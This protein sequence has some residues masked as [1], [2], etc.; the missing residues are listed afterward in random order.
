MVYFYMQIQLGKNKKNMTYAPCYHCGEPCQASIFEQAGCR[1]DEKIFCCQGCLAVYEL[2]KD[3]ELCQYYDLNDKAGISQKI[4]ARKEKFIY[5]DLPEVQAKL[6]DFTD[7]KTANLTL[8]IPAIHCS[9]CIW[10]LEHL[11]KLNENIHFSQINFLKKQLAIRFDVQKIKLSEVAALLASIGYEPLITLNDVQEEN[12]LQ[13]DRKTQQENRRLIAQIAVAGFVFGNV[14]MLSFPEY[15]GFD[16]LSEQNL[17]YVFNALNLVFSLPVLFFSGQDYITTA[18][19]NLRKGILHVDFPL[20]LGMLVLW[21]RSIFEIITETGAGYIDSMSGLIFFL[22]IGK[23]FQQRTYQ[24]M[25]YDR[26]FKSYFPIAVLVKDENGN[27]KPMQ[28]NDLASGNKIVI[29]NEEIIPADTQLLRGN[30]QIDYSFVTGEASPIQKEI[31]ETIYAGG[32]QKGE[33]IELLVLKK[34]SQSYLTQL[35]NNENFDKNKDENS[36][37]QAILNRYFTVVLILIACLSASYWLVFEKNIAVAINVFTAVLVIACPCALSLGSQFA[38]GTAM[39]ILG[40]H[41]FYLKNVHTVEQIAENDTIVFDKTGT[42]TENKES[43]IIFEPHN[44]L[45]SLQGL[46]E[47]EIS[48]ILA[49][50]RNSTHPLSVK[51]TNFLKENGYLI[52]PNQA[53]EIVSFKEQMGKGLEGIVGGSSVMIGSKKWLLEK[54]V[55]GFSETQANDNELDTKVFIALNGM[56]K[57]CF[58]FKNTYR[59]GIEQTIKSLVRADLD[60]YLLSGDNEGEKKNL[61]RLFPKENNL[62]FQQNPH[63][64][65]AFIKGLQAKN[66]HVMM[67]GDGLN[68][69]GALLQSDTGI[70]VTENTAYF[71]PAS[72]AIL[73]ASVLSKLPKFIKF[74]RFAV[75][76]IRQSFGI[77]LLYNLIGLFFAVQ[78]LLSPLVAAILMPVSSLTVILFTTWGVKRFK[79]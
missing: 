40:Q 66:R 24:T 60:L 53:A 67:V 62:Y 58:V 21:G 71:T 19:K 12:D 7:G 78:G 36:L 23:W 52:F 48:A 74:C 27:E 31:G 44:H 79:L 3:N 41:K 65:L 20:A 29:R 2:L 8:F 5:L 51:I 9:S 77:A 17:R 22:L 30:A 10:L 14:M 13:K 33:Q 38:L 69:A 18:Y 75:N 55:Q 56:Y 50:C 26:D 34:A 68:D 16:S 4:S 49:L 25:R 11:Y 1:S 15:F 42:I 32:R 57:G 35:W 63:Q 61:Q 70:A 47:K 54:G 45:E 6:F 64:K 73:D 76:K 37:L 28:V 46:S 72:D 59:E 43:K 39:R